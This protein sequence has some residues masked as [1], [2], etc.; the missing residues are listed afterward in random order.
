MYSQR[1]SDIACALRLLPVIAHVSSLCTA[2]RQTAN[3][4]NFGIGIKPFPRTPSGSTTSPY[5][6][7]G[8]P[9]VPKNSFVYAMCEVED[10]SEDDL[11]LPAFD[12]V[13]LVLPCD[14]FAVA[15]DSGL[16]AGSIIQRE[17]WGDLKL[18]LGP[19]TLFR[20]SHLC[21]RDYLCGSSRKT[22][23]DPCFWAFARDINTDK[24]TK[25]KIQAF[26]SPAVLTYNMK[27]GEEVFMPRGKSELPNPLSL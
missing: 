13:A 22:G 9:P 27:D 8:G 5:P 25:P 21:I 12:T 18:L 11:H 4:T 6:P 20:V 3:N 14:H 2:W 19:G 1:E 24:R 15:V 16:R 7:F 10:V 17:R 26:I 23:C